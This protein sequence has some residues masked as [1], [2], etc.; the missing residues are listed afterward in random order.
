MG[1]AGTACLVADTAD[2][3]I[4]MSH[5]TLMLGLGSAAL[6]AV[7]QSS[8]SPADQ[9]GDP[10]AGVAR[11]YEAFRDGGAEIPDFAHAVRLHALLDTVVEAAASGSRVSRR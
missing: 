8:M 5:I 7:S 1:T 2:G 9:L 4:Q 10:P 6:T 3:Q 11:M